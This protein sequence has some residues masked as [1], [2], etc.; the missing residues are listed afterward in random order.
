[1][2][3]SLGEPRDPKLLCAGTAFPAVGVLRTET[4]RPGG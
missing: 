1:M 4:E 3:L 2:N